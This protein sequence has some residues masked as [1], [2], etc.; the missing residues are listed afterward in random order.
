MTVLK[1]RGERFCQRVWDGLGIGEREMMDK[2][3]IN[4]QFPEDICL[5]GWVQGFPIAKTVFLDAKDRWK[6]TEN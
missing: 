6:T 5:K 2:E 3:L 4:C 1:W